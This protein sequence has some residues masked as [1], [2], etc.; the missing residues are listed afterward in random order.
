MASAA[1]FSNRA[2]RSLPFV[3]HPPSPLMCSTTPSTPT[4]TLANINLSGSTAS[5]PF[6]LL[7]NISFSASS[8]PLSA[9]SPST[10]QVPMNTP[11]SD[12]DGGISSPIE[13]KSAN[14]QLPVVL[15]AHHFPSPLLTPSVP[16]NSPEC[17]PINMSMIERTTGMS[18]DMT[19]SL[20]ERLAGL[21]IVA[22]KKDGFTDEEVRVLKEVVPKAPGT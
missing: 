20:G 7:S 22:A 17:V 16:P 9:G 6:S 4:N 13:T 18:E 19:A 11:H 3:S 14:I 8:S 12:V 2:A 1:A 5:N 15:E 10:L 21:S